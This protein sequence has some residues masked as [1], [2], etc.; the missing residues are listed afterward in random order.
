[1]AV[2]LSDTTRGLAVVRETN[3]DINARLSA[4]EERMK[5]LSGEVRR[6]VIELER[7]RRRTPEGKDE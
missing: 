4:V 7:N 3:A 1:M 5:E 6:L 2:A